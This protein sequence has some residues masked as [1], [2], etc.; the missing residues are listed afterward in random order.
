MDDCSTRH[1]ARADVADRC[2]RRCDTAKSAR[3]ARLGGTRPYWRSIA[4]AAS[5]CADRA[6]SSRSRRPARSA[7]RR[8]PD[9]PKST[10]STHGSNSR[11]RR[12]RLRA[13]SSGRRRAATGSVLEAE[14]LAGRT[15]ADAEHLAGDAR[16][17]RGRHG[18]CRQAFDRR[19][20]G[21]A[22][23]VAVARLARA[24]AAAPGAQPAAMRRSSMV[25]CAASYGR[26]STTRPSRFKPRCRP[27]RAARR[28]SGGRARSR[29]PRPAADRSDR[30]RCPRRGSAGR[31]AS[32]WL[33][34]SLVKPR[35][36][37]SSACGLSLKTP[38]R[39]LLEV[40]ERGRVVDEALAASR[41][42][43]MW[44]GAAHGSS[45]RDR[46]RR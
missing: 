10:T 37:P 1:R 4:A 26:R 34:R 39:P 5:G 20:A 40:V 43:R 31:S 42:A 18:P 38:A 8:A 16:E 14:G 32:V 2:R 21:D 29:S 11:R 41:P 13:S 23:A 33:L 9:D 12:S 3:A 6:R 17:W 35:Y 36:R 46:W 25:V 19:Y 27:A 15:V 45:G 22:R 44:P 24:A 30:R 28:S 7:D